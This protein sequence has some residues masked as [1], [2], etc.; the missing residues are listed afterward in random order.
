MDRSYLV[1]AVLTLALGTVG[2]HSGGRKAVCADPCPPDGG[3]EIVVH[4]P[5]QKVVVKTPPACPPE[6]ATAH[7]APQGMPAAPQTTFAAPQGVPQGFVGVPQGAAGFGAQ[8]MM[9][10]AP[11]GVPFGAGGANT[12]TT[13][14][15]NQRTRVALSFT[16][17]KIPLPW[18]KLIP[19]TEPTETTIR[20]TGQA[21]QA[22]GFGVPM[23]V[24]PAAAFGGG[25]LPGAPGS[26]VQGQVVGAPVAQGVVGA[27]A[28]AVCPPCP[29]ADPNAV[30]ITPER[31]RALTKKIEEL[32]AAK[33]AQEEGKK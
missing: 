17:I 32:E 2:C 22:Q 6:V 18:F 16:T 8:P 20:I 14:T 12:S 13:V 9:M 1:G 30:T 4:A 25:S 24:M 7:G 5:P 21:A 11:Q 27:Q 15:T 26:F 10:G 29:P 28:T 3:E 23:G 19:V 33:K 31:L